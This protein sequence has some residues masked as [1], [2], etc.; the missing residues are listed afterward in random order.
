MC[1][2]RTP[3]QIKLH[4]RLSGTEPHFSRQHIFIDQFPFFCRNSQRIWTARL[5]WPD[6]HRPLSICS[7]HSLKFLPVYGNSHFLTGIRFSLNS[8]QTSMLQYHIVRINFR[9]LQIKHM[10]CRFQ[11]YGSLFSEMRFSLFQKSAPVFYIRIIRYPFEVN[12]V[13]YASYDSR[14]GDSL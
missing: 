14:N 3:I 4:I 10:V 5:L 1:G 7:R 13:I 11:I 12:S 2:S 8:Q 9:H 6:I